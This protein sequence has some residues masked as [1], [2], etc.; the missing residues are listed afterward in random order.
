MSRVAPAPLPAAAGSGGSAGGLAAP[1][2]QRRR[3]I[4]QEP[5]AMLRGQERHLAR[6]AASKRRLRWLYAACAAACIATCVQALQLVATVAASRPAP[7]H[8]SHFLGY[9]LLWNSQP[10]TLALDWP[11]S[12]VPVAIVMAHALVSAAAACL[13]GHRWRTRE[14]DLG[15]FAA[16]PTPARAHAARGLR[17]ARAGLVVGALAFLVLVVQRAAV[18]AVVDRFYPSVCQL[19]PQYLRAGGAGSLLPLEGVS[20][21]ACAPSLRS[22]LTL[23]AHAQRFASPGKAALGP[24]VPDA[25]G[26]FNPAQAGSVGLALTVRH[27]LSVGCATFHSPP[28]LC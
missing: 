21:E 17:L 16:L 1:P 23:L 18:P 3:S 4:K 12:L 14:R 2:D 25:T 19:Q 7:P 10:N 11:A 20:A 22:T 26:A 27:S 15:G 6:V 9:Q 28:G 24:A 5:W 13:R 8:A